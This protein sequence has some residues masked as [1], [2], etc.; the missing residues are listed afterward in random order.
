M[1][2]ESLIWVLIAITTTHTLSVHITGHHEE[3]PAKGFVIVW[4]IWKTSQ[5]HFTVLLF[6][7]ISWCFQFEQSQGF[8]FQNHMVC[9]MESQSN[10]ELEIVFFLDNPNKYSTLYYLVAW[11][12]PRFILAFNSGVEDSGH[13]FPIWHFPLCSFYT[14]YKCWKNTSIHRGN[15]LPSYYEEKGFLRR[16]GGEGGERDRGT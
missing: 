7:A 1:E 4:P 6:L 12:S 8:W 16:E 3:S 9:H 2:H 15:S 10:L 14:L 11:K 5:F 13:C